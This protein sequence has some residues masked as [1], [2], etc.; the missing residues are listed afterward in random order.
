MMM[1]MMMYS[2]SG[3]TPAEG[4]PMRARAMYL[5]YMENLWIGVKPMYHD[6]QRQLRDARPDALISLGL[7]TILWPC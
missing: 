6:T 5:Y 7:V 2:Y 4:R 3:V 1:M